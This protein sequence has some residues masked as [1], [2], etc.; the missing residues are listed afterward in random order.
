[1]PRKGPKA[2]EKFIEALVKQGQDHIADKLDLEL[3]NIYRAAGNECIVVIVLS[4]CDIIANLRDYLICTRAKC[5]KPA[6]SEPQ[7]IL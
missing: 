7:K 6:L 2:F 3:T 1:L 4:T 5:I